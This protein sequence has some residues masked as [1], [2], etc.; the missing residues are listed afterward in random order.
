MNLTSDQKLKIQKI[1]SI[2]ETGK[3][4]GD[5]SNVTML[6]GDTGGLTYGLHQVTL[7]GGNLYLL[8]RAYLEEPMAEVKA[9]QSYLKPLK[10]KNQKLNRDKAL[11][12][13]LRQAG[14]D[15]VM[16][17]VQDEFFEKE[18]WQPAERWANKNG[19][20]LPLAMATIYDSFI[21][22]GQVAMY[23]RNRFKEVP[24]AAGGNEKAWIQAYVKARDNWLRHHQNEL[25]HKTVYRTE[26]FQKL[27]DQ[28]KWNLESPFKV[29]SFTL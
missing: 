29:R 8:V 15:P 3:P 9:L 25:L 21:H 23:L 12:V 13:L 16:R 6:K 18:Y 2:F 11:H 17:A 4:E 1:L 22:S 26:A 20:T 28:G 10:D 27:I 7:N 24:P 5:Y 19:F 14:E